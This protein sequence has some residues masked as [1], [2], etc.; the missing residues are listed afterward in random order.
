MI[1]EKPE[2]TPEFIKDKIASVPFWL[3]RIEIAPGIFTP[4]LSDTI[5]K[6]KK[7]GLPDD[8]TGKR[9]LDVGPA[10]GAYSFECERRGAEV[11]AIEPIETNRGFEVA[12]E[13]LGSKVPYMRRS[14]YE[15]KVSDLGKFDIV[16]FMGV[17]YHLRHPLL[18]LDCLHEMFEEQLI[19]ETHVCDRG[20]VDSEGKPRALDEYSPELEKT[21]MAQFFPTSELNNDSSNWWGFNEYGLRRALET[22]GYRVTYFER[23]IRDRVI[24]HC[25]KTKRPKGTEFEVSEMLKGRLNRSQIPSD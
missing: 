3:H 12:R 20:Y 16:L 18:A 19:L 8:L 22:S 2:F 13:L 14:V 4:G 6:M 23:F 7:I 15:L 10:E 1:E 24:L 25:E 21:C 5:L 9:V 17:L 11:V